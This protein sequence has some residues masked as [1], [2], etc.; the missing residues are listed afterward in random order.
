M[1]KMKARIMALLGAFA[2]T[3]WGI[4]LAACSHDGGGSPSPVT[5][6]VDNDGPNGGGG[7]NYLTLTAE[8]KSVTAPETAGAITVS[9]GASYNGNDINAAW[10]AIK[11]ATG[12]VV[13]TL[14]AGTYTVTDNTN[15]TY[16]GS[17]NIKI[18]GKPK[19]EYGLDVLIQGNTGSNSMKARELLYFDNNSTGSLTLEY[20]TLKNNF[21][22]TSTSDVQAEVIGTAGT[23]NLA[24][25]SCSFISRQDTIR[26]VAKAWFYHCY[27][28]GDVDFLWME[29]AGKV[30]LYEDCVIRAVSDRVSNAYFTAPR[31]ALTTK[32]GKGLVIYNSVLEAE[33]GLGNQLF[34]GRNPW[35]GSLTGQYNNVAIV[36]TPLYLGEGVSL[37]DDIWK[38]PA[39]GTSDQQYVGYKTDDYYAKSAKYGARLSAAV[40]SAEYAGRRNI[41]NRD[42]NMGSKKFVKDSDSNWD[43][44]ALITANGWQVADD[45]SKDLLDGE[46]ETVTKVYDFTAAS[47]GAYTDKTV[48]IDGFTNHSSGSAT[49]GPGTTITIPLT[50]K[51]VVYVSGFYSGYGTIKAASQKD[52]VVYDFNNNSTSTVI[53]KVYAVYA[54]NPGNLIITATTTTYITKI[55]VEY[56][57]SLTYTPVSA[58][59]VSGDSDTHTVGVPL[60][61]S[62]TVTPGNATNTDVKWSSSE[63]TVGTVNEYTGEVKFTKAGTVTFTATAR[64]G[65][66][67][68]GTITC[69]PK[70]AT[71]KSAEWYDSKDS[72]STKTSG[73]G[74]GLGGSAGENNSIFTLGTTSGVTLGGV[75]S[76][77]GIGGTDLS[78]STGLKMDS[79]GT[80]TFSVTKNATVLVKTGY[81]SDSNVTNDTLK[82][83]ASDGATA[84]ADSG[85]PSGTPTADA[86][87][88]WTLTPGIYTVGRASG[89]Y[90][91]SIYYVRVDITE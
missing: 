3:V 57:D 87:Y 43:I 68:T 48:T 15:L 44:D 70:E 10:A 54:A 26:T 17:Y 34:L 66:G 71:W 11:N 24:A 53:E 45:S 73:D 63:E 22:F 85:N 65:S 19:S 52:E 60:K 67:K 37:N 61:L 78:I 50:G 84:T 76:V 91:P 7:G 88:K 55:V 75:K 29:S 14:A 77:T 49:G 79:K 1:K 4:G 32:V 40:K 56:D 36:S 59:A 82:I 16:S 86:D 8:R 81:C 12:D 46:K 42:Y 72:S 62:A 47:A 38:S 58:I 69:T 6:P 51:A 64:D 28:E 89:G 80:V 9:G 41:L 30:A 18:T 74:T 13:M 31:A 27:I 20:V 21:A 35:S 90:A 33:E 39:N 23:G 2:L 25:Y 83:T 5:P